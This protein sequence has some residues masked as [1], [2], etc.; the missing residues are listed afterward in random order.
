MFV[1]MLSWVLNRFLS[2]YILKLSVVEH[3]GIWIHIA[4]SW[5]I[6]YS[7]HVKTQNLCM[8]VFIKLIK[9]CVRE[10]GIETWNY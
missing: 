4:F 1:E 8:F 2:K 7:F 6:L 3:L 10:F 9:I 5:T